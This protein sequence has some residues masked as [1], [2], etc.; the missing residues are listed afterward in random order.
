MRAAIRRSV[1]ALTAAL[2]LGLVAGCTSD[3]GS[4]SGSS[5][6]SQAA[7]LPAPLPDVELE[8][9][10]GGEPLDLAEL[11]GPAVVNF[12]ASWCGPCRREMP[13]LEEFAQK[14]AGEVEVVGIDF[15]D[16]QTDAA[17]DLV[18]ETGVTYPLYVDQD[19]VLDRAAPFPHLRGLPFWA[20]VDAEGRVV[21]WQFLEIKDLAQLEELVETHLGVA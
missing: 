2:L 10:D 8:G 21:E 14:H 15:Q 5:G 9:F 1:A 19:G 12:W 20:F 4:N 13:I 17:R 18:Q 3:D 11:R 16:V 7:T 6:G